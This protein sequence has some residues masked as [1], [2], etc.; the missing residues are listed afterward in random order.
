MALIRTLPQNNEAP[1]WAAILP[2]RTPSPSIE[3]EIH[4]DWVVLGAGFTGLAAAR[5][6]GEM[7]PDDRI[8]I[9]DAGEVGAGA[10]GRNSGFAIDHAHTLGGGVA[11]L[12]SAR[13]QK[14]LYSAAIEGMAEIVA[15]HEIECDWRNDGK[16]HGAASARGTEAY[17]KPLLEELDH[18]DE[19]HRWLNAREME[20]ELGINHYAAGIYTPGTVLVNP[21]ALVRGL[22]GC[23]PENV[24]LAENSPVTTIDIAGPIKLTTLKGQVVAKRMILATNAFTPEM[25]FFQ[26]K[27][28]PFVGFASLS[29]VL[30]AGEQEA[31]GGRASWGLTPANA[32]VGATIQ[33][34]GDN[35]ILFR[36]TIT[37]RDNLRHSAAEL[38]QVRAR[39][40]QLFAARFAMLPDV[41]LDHTW[42]G[43]L[44][45]SR[46]QDSAF[47]KFADNVWGAAGHQGIGVTRGTISGTLAADMAMG[48]DNPLLEDMMCIARPVSN[49][50][51]PL[52]DLG[53]A[54]NTAW[55]AWRN[56]DEA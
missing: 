24:T 51:S 13:G 52:L 15:A 25:G 6:L 44:S 29:R 3:G 11:A 21:A 55:D 34:T 30:T 20:A 8:I 22:A 14:R 45:L 38:E 40:R 18:I 49:P 54:L 35:R 43:Y 17:L 32:F 2:P 53:I 42:G 1:G 27:L 31:L 5:R 9:V 47:G 56:R 19:P 48:L 10:S 23:L 7:R 39:H 33:R 4:G 26:R 36:Q 12:E 41:T 28:L 46:N 50:P 37:Y 16:F